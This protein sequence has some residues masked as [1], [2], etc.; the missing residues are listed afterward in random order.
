MGLI[1]LMGHVDR[2]LRYTVVTYIIR[3]SIT[4]TLTNGNTSCAVKTV[5]DLLELPLRIIISEYLL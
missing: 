1:W 4:K 3:Q 5:T 2:C